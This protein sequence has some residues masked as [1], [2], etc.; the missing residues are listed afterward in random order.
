MALCQAWI[1]TKPLWG[2]LQVILIIPSH[3]P[4]NI[5]EDL[6]PSFHLDAVQDRT[7]SLLFGFRLGFI[8]LEADPDPAHHQSNANLRP[9]AYRPSEILF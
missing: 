7:F 6:D 9:L 4:N 1:S 3:V 5:D 8:H 2:F